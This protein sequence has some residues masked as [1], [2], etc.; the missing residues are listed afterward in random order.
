MNL[1]FIR[2]LI[3]EILNPAG[4]LNFELNAKAYDNLIQKGKKKLVFFGMQ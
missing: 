1:M 2:S 4:R 3:Y